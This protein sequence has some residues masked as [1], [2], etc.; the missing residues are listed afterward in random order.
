MAS[1]TD[2]ARQFIDE[3]DRVQEA[4]DAAAVRRALQ[5]ILF[6]MMERI[7]AGEPD[8]AAQYLALIQ[9]AL[10]RIRAV[11]AALPDEPPADAARYAYTIVQA[12]QVADRALDSART[13]VELASV[14]SE[15]KRDVL[16]ILV[17]EGAHRHLSRNDIHE[18]L[19]SQRSQP[20]SAHRIG[21]I[22]DELHALNLLTRVELPRRGGMTA[23]YHLTPTGRQLCT[24]L[25]RDEQDEI[26]SS[27]TWMSE[28]AQE[29]FLQRRMAGS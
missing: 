1:M 23:H 18:H 8:V 5:T 26:Q 3:L 2:N 19:R 13:Q 16:R 25:F 20:L 6:D 12:L 11:L 22:L 28:E 24:R 9:P 7:W 14:G 17:V 29:E 27:D 4:G 10:P 21:Q 15:S